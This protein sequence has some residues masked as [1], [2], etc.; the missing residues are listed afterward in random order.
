LIRNIIILIAGFI[1][2]GES[3]GKIYPYEWLGYLSVIILLICACLGYK[4]FKNSEKAVVVA[5]PHT[6]ESAKRSGIIVRI[7][8]VR[9]VSKKPGRFLKPSWFF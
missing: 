5:E 2:I 6:S 1:V 7:N 8:F 3:G 4:I 9:Q